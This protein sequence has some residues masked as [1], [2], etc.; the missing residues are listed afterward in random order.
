VA[1]GMLAVSREALEYTLDNSA[2][3]EPKYRIGLLLLDNTQPND[4][5][6]PAYVTF[7]HVELLWSTPGCQRRGG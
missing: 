7:A 4:L 5:V 3:N 2:R 1:V 6:Q